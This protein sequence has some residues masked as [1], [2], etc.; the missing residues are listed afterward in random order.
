MLQPTLKASLAVLSFWV[1][2][3]SAWGADISGEWEFT[4]E[5][6][7]GSGNPIFTFQQEGEKLRGTYSGAAGKSVLTGS[8]KDDQVKWK[9]TAQYQGMDFDVVYEGTIESDNAMNGTCD[10]GG[11]VS[12]TWTAKRVK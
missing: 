5:L 6:D 12:G 10:Y 1:L 7:M 2:S 9:F 4:V 8:V 3:V 11:Q